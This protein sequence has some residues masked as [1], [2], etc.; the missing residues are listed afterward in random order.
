M[1]LSLLSRFISI[2]QQ[3]THVIN[4]AQPP[5][6]PPRLPQVEYARDFGRQRVHGTV[7]HSRY[8]RTNPAAPRTH[9]QR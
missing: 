1:L 5:A 2:S 3:A 7:L 8:L 9:A 6:Q 4:V